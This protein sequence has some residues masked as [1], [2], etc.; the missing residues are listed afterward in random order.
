[1]VMAPELR[2]PVF[3]WKPEKEDPEKAA[4]SGAEAATRATARTVAKHFIVVRSSNAERKMITFWH[5]TL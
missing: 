1:M 2:T 5:S 3:N 4:A